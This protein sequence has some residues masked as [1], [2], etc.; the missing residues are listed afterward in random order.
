MTE[1][2]LFTNLRKLRHI[3]PSQNWVN[4]T[5]NQILHLPEEK[6]ALTFTST[7]ERIFFP[8]FKPALAGFFVV[9]VLFGLFGIVKNA[10]PG[11][12]L[13]IIRRV[14]HVGENILTSE[15]DKPA[16]QLRLAND[17]LEDLTKVS[18][19]NLAPTISEFQAN[20]SEAAKEI[21]R[22]DATTSSPTV[23][24]KIVAGTK[25]LKENQQKAES[26]GVVI[27]GTEELDNALEK[28]AGNLIEDLQSRTLTEANEEVLAKMKGFF[29]QEKYSEVLELY[30]I[31]Q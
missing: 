24:R 28:I 9:F 7:F 5:K 26:L 19:R 23:I 30:L 29:S 20:V 22:I 8:I 6:S 14:A 12:A 18:A 16:L 4:L 3:K 15:A 25:K 17:R 10:M 21:S 27:G 11:D 1:K 2:E 13:Y 31:N